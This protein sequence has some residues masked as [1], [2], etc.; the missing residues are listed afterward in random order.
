MLRRRLN[1][2]TRQNRHRVAR[3]EPLNEP[4]I[5]KT[6]SSGSKRRPEQ[7]LQ[8]TSWRT[9]RLQVGPGLDDTR[10]EALKSPLFF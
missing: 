1:V 8:L 9:S 10:F 6:Q 7:R 5:T 3:I 4:N 2:S